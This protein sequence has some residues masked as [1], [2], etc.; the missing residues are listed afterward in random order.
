[1]FPR[2]RLL[3]LTFYL[4]LAWLNNRTTEFGDRRCL[5]YTARTSIALH[6]RAAAPPPCQPP[7]LPLSSPL[8]CQNHRGILLDSPSSSIIMVDRSSFIATLLY[9]IIYYYER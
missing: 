4:S 3:V 7:S 2:T 9:Y 1:M 5:Q 8:V 6:L